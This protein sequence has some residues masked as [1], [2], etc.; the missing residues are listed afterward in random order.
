MVRGLARVQ[1]V[2]AK[3]VCIDERGSLGWG[4]DYRQ[5]GPAVL[6]THY[7]VDDEGLPQL[8]TTMTMAWGLRATSCRG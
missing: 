6:P 1:G 7:L 5:T 2:A 8:V 4:H 3:A